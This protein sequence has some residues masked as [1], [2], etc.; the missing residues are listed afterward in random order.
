MTT[1]LQNLTDP[2]LCRTSWPLCQ[3]L[4]C[5]DETIPSGLCLKQAS[6]Q[7]KVSNRGS[8]QR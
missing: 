7:I 4:L 6:L 2:T 1:V 5:T 8:G 3:S